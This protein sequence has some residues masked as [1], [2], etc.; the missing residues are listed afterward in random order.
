MNY[1][2]SLLFLLLARMAYACADSLHY[3]NLV[4]EGGGVRGIAYAGAL[5]VLNQRGML[6]QVERVGGTSVGSITALLLAVGYSTDE[7]TAILSD[8]HI[9]RFNDGRWFFI[10]GLHRMVRRFGWYRGEQFERWLEELIERKTGNRELT[11]AQL[12]QRRSEGFRDLYVTGTNLTAQRPVVFSHQHTPDMALKTAVRISMSVPLYFGAVFLDDQQR[13]VR[14]PKKGHTYQILVD[15]GLTANYP[16]DLFD[17]EGQPNDETLGLKLER[18]EQLTHDQ[19][20]SGLAPYSIR[21]FNEYIGAFYTYVIENLNRQPTWANE[22]SRTIY[23][24]M[25]GIRPRVRRM[26]AEETQRLYESGQRAARR[27]Q[28]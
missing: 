14:R 16:L 23:I 1:G 26:R 17:V 21:S 10:G 12:H 4:F 13:V 20:S 6:Q 24:S 11:F 15:S 3:K 7:M 8:L 9:E 28:P 18:P 25:E 2:F 19:A 5:N 22:K 27:F